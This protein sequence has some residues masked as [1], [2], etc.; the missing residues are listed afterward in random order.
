MG[1]GIRIADRVR[2]LGKKRSDER[3]IQEEKE[4]INGRKTSL[5]LCS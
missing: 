2:E 4:A 5:G 1:D 3:G